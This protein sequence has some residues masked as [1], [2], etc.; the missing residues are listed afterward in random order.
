MSAS[1]SAFPRI[2]VTLP[3]ANFTQRRILEGVLSYAR[4]HGPWMFHLN[5]G[6]VAGQGLR[7]ISDWKCSGIIALSAHPELIARLAALKRPAVFINPPQEKR[8]PPKGCVFVRRDHQ[9][10]GRLAAE[11]FIDRGY[12][13]FAFVGSARPAAWSDGRRDGFVARLV[14][15]GHNCSCYPDPTP[16]EMADFA[17]EAPR[18]GAWLAALPKPTALYTVKDMRGQQILA[19]CMD[20][21]V[22][23]PEDLSVLSTDDDA[24][25]CETTTPPLSSIALDG[26]NTGRLCARILDDLLHGRPTE[27]LVDIAYPRIVTRRSTDAFAID[28]PILARAV[29]HVRAHLGESL[30][31]A[32]LAESLGISVRTIEMKALRHLGRPFR[33]EIRRIRLSEGISLLSNTA[34]SIATIAERCGF[35]NA[36]HFARTVKA[37]F[38]YTPGTFRARSRAPQRQQHAPA[39]S[40]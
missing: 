4:E 31:I 40:G 30:Q 8:R 6:D 26:E 37:A 19:A 39:R 29:A 9:N 16:G 22:R 20:A 32:A 13:S 25:L 35:C 15:A 21:G 38:G 34:L 27:P 23:V 14:K 2:L 17:V 3:T 11:Y 36:S 1:P 28:D 33:E 24:V 10:L 5:T 7:R 12:R 18:L